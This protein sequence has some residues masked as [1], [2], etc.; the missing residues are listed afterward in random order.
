M[1]T[2]GLLGGLPSMLLQRLFAFRRLLV[3]AVFA[4]LMPVDEVAFRGESNSTLPQTEYSAIS[5]VLSRPDV[6]N[7]RPPQALETPLPT[8]TVRR[9]ASTP[10]RPPSSHRRSNVQN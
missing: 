4:L 2:L 3:V 10:E 1:N 8:A 9:I 5:S 6:A 7:T